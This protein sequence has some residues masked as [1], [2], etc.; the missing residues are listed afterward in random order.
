M[1]GMCFFG[2]MIGTFEQLLQDLA[3]DDQ[4]V[5]EQDKL[6]QWII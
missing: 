4:F 1:V 2:Y 5:Q 6:D 3:N